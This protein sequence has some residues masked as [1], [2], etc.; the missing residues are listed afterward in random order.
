MA[1]STCGSIYKC[2]CLVS[3][4]PIDCDPCLK[5]KYCAEKMDADCVYYNLNQPDEPSLLICSGIPSDTPLTVILEKFD[6]MLCG[7]VSTFAI[8]AQDTNSVDMHVSAAGNI[9]TISADVRIDPASTAPVSV[10]SAGIKIDC[11]GCTG[12]SFSKSRAITGIT[13]QSSYYS[14]LNAL[15]FTKSDILTGLSIT[16]SSTVTGDTFKSIKYTSWLFNYTG[17]ITS[18]PNPVVLGGN[19]CAKDIIGKTRQLLIEYT[20]T[21]DC[22][23]YDSCNLSV[24][25]VAY[26]ERHNYPYRANFQI[27]APPIM[28][29][30]TVSPALD[31]GVLY[32]SDVK[33]LNPSTSNG[34]LIKKINLNTLEVLTLSGS[35]TGGTSGSTV[36]N[37]WGDVVQYDYGSSV[38]LDSTQMVNG[39][40][41]IYFCTFGGVVCRLVRERTDQCDER[42]NWKTYIIAGANGVGDYPSASSGASSLSTGSNARFAHPYGLKKFFTYNGYPMFLIADQQNDKIKLIYYNGNINPGGPNNSD[43]WNVK[44]FGLTLNGGGIARNFNVEND[45]F[46]SGKKRLVIWEADSIEFRPF[47]IASPTLSDITTIGNYGSI[48]A[49]NS[50]AGNVDGTGTGAKV[51]N[52]SIIS[53]I[54]PPS[55]GDIYIFSQEI[56]GLPGL[57]PTGSASRL[58]YFTSTGT[59]GPADHFFVSLVGN[60]TNP[61]GSIGTYSN[62]NGFTQGFFTDLQGNIYDITIGGLRLWDFAAGS[63]TTVVSG[64]SSVSATQTVTPSDS[65][66]TQY[67]ITLTC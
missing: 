8:N 9:Y 56:A 50:T 51:D 16:D 7:F 5:N 46:N 23:S 48:F 30:P 29:D 20:S 35:V 57:P 65:M 49:V 52:V 66:D 44:N 19:V 33:A 55:I 53:K 12:V 14:T 26:S 59:S 64:G 47:S 36:N 3:Q 1:C 58:R 62:I 22:Y 45:P 63:A 25:R 27:D 42:A 31:K 21:K 43:N 28:A 32:F 39:E 40:P 17:I 11:C 10:S 15:Y 61:V 37:S 41:T 4:Y 54:S 34:G 24:N 60:N 6:Q 2:N 13:K 38:C 67:A 18:T